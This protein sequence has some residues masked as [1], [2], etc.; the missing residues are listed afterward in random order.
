MNR[1]QDCSRDQI[2]DDSGQPS[3]G[4]GEA[5]EVVLALAARGDDSAV[6]QA[7]PDDG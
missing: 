2:L 6:A 7:A 3:A 5:V 1:D 4:V